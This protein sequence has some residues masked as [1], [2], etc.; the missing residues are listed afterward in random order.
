MG[1]GLTMNLF[2]FLEKA[3]C[4]RIIDKYSFIKRYNITKLYNSKILFL[5][6]I[7]INLRYLPRIFLMEVSTIFLLTILIA[8][9]YLVFSVLFK[10][11]IIKFFAIIGSLFLFDTMITSIFN[12][13][14]EGIFTL[15]YFL[16]QG[17]HSSNVN[18]IF[19]EFLTLYFVKTYFNPSQSNLELIIEIISLIYSFNLIFF[20][21]DFEWIRHTKKLSKKEIINLGTESYKSDHSSEQFLASLIHDLRNPVS[22]VHSLLEIIINDENISLIQKDQLETALFSCD[23]QLMIINNMLDLS[24][25]RASKFQLQI[26]HFSL[27]RIIKMIVKMESNL[28]K[29]KRLKY[30]VQILNTLPEIVKGDKNRISQIILNLIGNAIKFTEKGCIQ[31]RVRWEKDFNCIDF[32]D[33]S[34]HKLIP[35]SGKFNSLNHNTLVS[36]NSII[37]LKSTLK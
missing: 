19:N 31:I 34:L 4:S 35:G 14:H 29:K 18:M 5:A 7:L 10:N 13:V 9:L 24:K 25:I 8:F 11:D 16:Q 32:S 12:S 27:P 6:M 26:K 37:H 17:K 30:S 22:T 1:M 2:Q 28:A 3:T 23:F 20:T 33:E 21:F 15:L 36:S